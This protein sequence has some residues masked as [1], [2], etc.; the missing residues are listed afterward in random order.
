MPLPSPLGGEAQAKEL[1]AV[2]GRDADVVVLDVNAHALH[3][4]GRPRGLA[5][6]A[7]ALVGPAAVSA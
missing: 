7:H 1:G 5:A 2:L 6:D 3:A 4:A